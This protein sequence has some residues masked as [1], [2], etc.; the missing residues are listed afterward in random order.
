METIVETAMLIS[1]Q[2]VNRLAELRTTFPTA[3]DAELDDYLNEIE[4]NH[5]E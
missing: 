3:T 5:D 2:L 4:Q 1:E